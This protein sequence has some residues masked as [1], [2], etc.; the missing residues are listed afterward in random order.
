MTQLTP[1]RS[2]DP[3]LLDAGQARVW[4]LPVVADFMQLSKMRITLMVVATSAIGYFLALPASTQPQANWWS[5]LATLVGTGLSCVGAG[6]L[7][8]A[9]ERDTDARMRR[10][11]RRPLPAGR[12]SILTAVT[13]GMLTGLLGVSILALF[14]T[15]M[16]AILS[17]L[18]IVLY[19]VIYTPLKRITSL[20]T[21]IGAVPG[22]MPPLI[23]AAAVDGMIGVGG[24]LAF[25]IMFVWQ[26]P[27]FY[28]IAWLYRDDYTKAGMPM[29]P[30]LD[31]TGRSTFRQMLFWS[32][33][34]LPVGLLPTWLGISGNT[35]FLIALVSGVCF[36]A[37]GIAMILGQSVRQA[38]AMFLAS[39]VYLPLVLG[40][41]VLNRP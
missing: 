5:L 7:N 16:A 26:M 25:L 31:P 27:H 36:L 11:C 13:Y 9:Y 37:M 12:M 29:L 22:A 32:V 18:T 40:A 35:C 39:L 15:A 21:I 3:L 10:T 38:R 2:T 33:L 30:V 8:Q 17:A 6:A 41:M 1:T 20:S 24:W 4:I 23:G 34:L 14:T 19:V 28:A